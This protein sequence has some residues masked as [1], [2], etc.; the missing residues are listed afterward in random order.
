MEELGEERLGLIKKEME[1]HAEET[2]T[3]DQKR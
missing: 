3:E 1:G 2:G